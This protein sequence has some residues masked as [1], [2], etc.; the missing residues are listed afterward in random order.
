MKFNLQYLV[1]LPDSE[2]SAH[3][4]RNSHP[5]EKPLC[6]KFFWAGLGRKALQCISTGNLAKRVRNL[7][8]PEKN[9]PTRSPSW[10]DSSS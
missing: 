9:S 3:R 4:I 5:L 10:V 8:P 7:C 1:R 6:E 2:T